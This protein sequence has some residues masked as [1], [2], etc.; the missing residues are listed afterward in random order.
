M[1]ALLFVF[2]FFFSIGS[3]F[4]ANAANKTI[5]DIH[6]FVA[7][8]LLKGD[9]TIE[10]Y[11][12]PTNRKNVDYLVAELKKMADSIRVKDGAASKV[13]DGKSEHDDENMLFVTVP[14]AGCW[15]MTVSQDVLKKIYSYFLKGPNEEL[16]IS[17][18]GGA[19]SN[20]PPTIY[21]PKPI[22][23]CPKE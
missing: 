11:Y 22:R 10:F 5:D 19:S 23:K 15:T 3:G 2:S 21:W 4:S 6:T 8:R 16:I 1:K 14:S 13:R 7:P 9:Y 17:G 12:A 20:S 18:F